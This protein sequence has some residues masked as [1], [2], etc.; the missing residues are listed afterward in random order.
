MSLRNG[1]EYKKVLKSKIFSRYLK[2]MI[3]NWE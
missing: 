3:W 1:K 2:L